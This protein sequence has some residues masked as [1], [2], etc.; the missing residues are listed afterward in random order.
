M[1]NG[2]IVI[3]KTQEWTSMDV[4]DKIRGGSTRKGYAASVQQRSC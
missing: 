3:D 4:C 2:I 1:A